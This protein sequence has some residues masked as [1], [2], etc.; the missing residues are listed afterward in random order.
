M[1]VGNGKK[2]I[3]PFQYPSLTVGGLT[4]G[5][6]PVT[7]GV[8]T[9]SLLATVTTF[10]YVPTQWFS[11]AQGQRPKGLFYLGYWMVLLFK[12]MAMKT[13]DICNFMLRLQ[14]LAQYKACQMGYAPLSC[15]PWP[16]AGKSLLSVCG[17]GL[18]VP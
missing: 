9:D 12:V 10:G 5:A 15:L 4:L 14:D 11:P 6:M 1:V 17:H 7:A 2:F 13:D 3:F 18:I 16:H 8:I